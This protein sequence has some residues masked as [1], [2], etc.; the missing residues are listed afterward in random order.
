MKKRD[1]LK[2]TRWNNKLNEIET[3]RKAKWNLRTNF[4]H[5][6]AYFWYCLA[7]YTLG[8]MLLL[9]L[10]PR[11]ASTH[12]HTSRFEKR[13]AVCILSVCCFFCHYY[14]TTDTYVG[15][16]SLSVDLCV[17]VRLEKVFFFSK[18]CW[19]WVWVNRVANSRIHTHFIRHIEI[20]ASINT[21]ALPEQAVSQAVLATP[22][23]VNFTRERQ[24]D[25]NKCNRETILNWFIAGGRRAVNANRTKLK[26]AECT[27]SIHPPQAN[28]RNS[29]GT[30]QAAR[31]NS[32]S[33]HM[34]EATKKKQTQNKNR[35]KT[36]ENIICHSNGDNLCWT[37][38][39]IRT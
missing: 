16:A 24:T 29:Y 34:R 36:K 31:A 30:H 17:S 26:N 13:F 37:M 4:T 11:R 25:I 5:K 8:R 9:L 22:P 20:L 39:F 2:R 6:R 10:A 33:T 38:I 23:T 18:V 14:F 1:Y 28:T 15:T 19:I 32:L 27:I 35:Q 7:C 21:H 12:T 3:R